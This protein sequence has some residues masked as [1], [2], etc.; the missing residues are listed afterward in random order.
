MSVDRRQLTA[1]VC[2][3]IAMVAVPVGL[4][5]TAGGFFLSRQ[6]PD[7]GPTCDGKVMTPGTECWSFGNDSAGATSYEHAAEAR[8]NNLE[9]AKGLLPA[10]LTVLVVGVTGAAVF[11]RYTRSST[12]TGDA[13]GVGPASVDQPPDRRPS[14]AELE[15]HATSALDQGDLDG[16]LY[17]YQVGADSGNPEAM[18]KLA[19]LLQHDGNIA[20]AEFWHRRASEAAQIAAPETSRSAHTLASEMDVLLTM[21]MGNHATADRLIDFEQRRDPSADRAA[22]IRTAIQ[23][24]HEDRHRQG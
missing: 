4:I 23:R 9:S 14:L 5:M 11:Y 20:E 2:M 7:A 22:S 17:W 18:G 24:L 21:V 15:A 1:G 12:G 8:R 6:D 19:A 3:L 16:A 10:G 13:H